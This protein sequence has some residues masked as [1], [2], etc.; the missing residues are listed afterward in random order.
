MTNFAQRFREESDEIKYYGI[1]PQMT[2]R[3]L[4]FE[5]RTKDGCRK[6]YS[7]SYMIDAEFKPE[8][9][10]IINVSDVIVTIKGRRLDEIYAYLLSNRL[11]YV[12][13][14][15]SG[16][17]TGDNNLFVESIEILQRTP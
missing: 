6:A 5:L 7:Y 4:M 8:V 17:D 13:E 11:S 3:A 16:H 2:S 1:E 10:I 12:Q 14:D 9:G 15:Y